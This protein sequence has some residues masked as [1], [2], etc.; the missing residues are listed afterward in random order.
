MTT[1]VEP[2]SRT[3]ELRGLRFHYLDWGNESAPALVLLHGLGGAAGEW[4][5]VGEHFRSHYRV[6]ALDQRGHGRSGH[7]A[8]R[9]YATDDFVADLEAFLDALG[10]D[11]AILCGHSMGGHNVIAF[12]AR[13]PARVVC[14]L[15][16]DIPPALPR[17][18]PAAAEQFP[19]GRQPLF[20]NVEQF[21]AADRE[22]NPFTPEDARR[23]VAQ[24]RLAPVEG[25]YRSTADPNAAIEWAPTDLWEAART[26]TRPV[27]LVRGGASTVLDAETLRRMEDA[28]ER[29]R[30][31]TLERA[32]HNTF[33]DMEQEFL[34]A[35]SQ[36]FAEHGG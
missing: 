3:L 34:D 21:L 6:L 14:G 5:R 9:A 4:R 25:G 36:F 20:A 7:A 27:L 24:A 30:S 32:G 23:M 15:A 16:N 8:D 12:A 17:D 35:A 31:V 19:G 2:T 22:R 13:H 11:R 10:I 28:I 29:A 18:R 1:A 33:L 26:I